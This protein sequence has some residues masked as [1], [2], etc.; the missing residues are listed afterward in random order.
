MALTAINNAELAEPYQPKNGNIGLKNFKL[1]THNVTTDSSNSPRLN[2]NF[3]SNGRVEME[4]KN[5]QELIQTKAVLEQI[6][7]T[8]KP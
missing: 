5:E 8:I 4:P 3:S 7:N 6:L 1:L 2:V